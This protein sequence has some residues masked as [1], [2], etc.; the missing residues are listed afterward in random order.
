MAKKDVIKELTS[1]KGIGKAKAEAIADNGFDDIEKIKKA[2]KKDLTKIS[3]ITDSLADKIINNYQKEEPK[4]KPKKTEKKETKTVKKEGK[5][6]KKSEPKK[7][8]K[9]EKED[10]EEEKPK[11]KIKKKP[12]LNSEIKEELEKRKEIKNRTPKFRREEWFRYKRLSKNWRRPDGITSKMRINKKYRPSRV[13]VGFR[14]PKKTRGLHS[15]GFE[16]VM[17][18]NP[19]DLEKLD[20]DT[21]AARI[22]SSVGT[23]KRI[24]IEESAKKLDIRILNL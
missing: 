19:K 18:F 12:K 24:D 8:K 1:I 3:G 17:V 11:K 23:K 13:R 22:G 10:E 4:E 14:G 6:K 2:K 16:E 5:T 20:P 9:E 7:T 15:S 21:Q